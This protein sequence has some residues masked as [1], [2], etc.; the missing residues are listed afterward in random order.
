MPHA[1]IQVRVPFADVDSS[2]RIH[3][4]AMFRY[5]EIA[6]HELMRAIG[7]PYSTVMST[8]FR[9]IAFPRV[10]L[11]CDYVK[12]IVYDDVLTIEADVERVGRSSWTISFAARLIEHAGD[13]VPDEGEIAARGKM[14]IV[15]MDR[16]SE[17][18]RPLPD[19]L[20]AAL[21]AD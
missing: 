16:Q 14:T 8:I 19:A 12:G 15:A 4:T 11:S 5:M 1:S 9:D 7:V 20:R 10:H 13:A 2:A 17:R 21:A 18:A 3:F 6:E